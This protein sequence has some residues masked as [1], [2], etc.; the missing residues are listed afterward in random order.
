[1]N[2]KDA[3]SSSFW[4]E[5]PLFMMLANNDYSIITGKLKEH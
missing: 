5:F 4:L 3:I 2:I 1:M